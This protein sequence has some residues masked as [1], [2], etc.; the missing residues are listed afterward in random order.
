[1]GCQQSIPTDAG[2]SFDVTKSASALQRT[3]INQIAVTGTFKTKTQSAT[4]SPEAS[5][6]SLR[7]ARTVTSRSIVSLEVD[8]DSSYLLPKLDCNGHLLVEEIVRRTSSSLH[9]SSITVGEGTETFKLQYAYRSQRG[10]NPREPMKPNQEKYGVTLNFAGEGGGAMMGIYSGHGEE[11][12]QCANFSQRVLPQQLAKFVRHKRVQKYR[13]ILQAAGNMKQGAWNPKMWPLL[14]FNDYEQCCERAFRETNKM[15]HQEKDIDDRFSGASVAS[16]CF[17]GGRMYVCNVG[18]SS[19]ILGRRSSDDCTQSSKNYTVFDG[20]EEKCEIEEYT[21]D[22]DPVE[23]AQCPFRGDRIA[24]PLTVK[25]TIY[26]QEEQERVKLAGAEVKQ[27]DQIED[28]ESIYDSKELYDSDS[29]PL[30]AFLPGKS[31][32]S[33]RVT[34]SIG[35]NASEQIGIVSDPDV[36]E[37]DLTVNDDILIIASN[38]ALE[39]LT[40]QE[41]VS[42]CAAN[43][44]PLQASESVTRA[45]YEKWIEHKNRCDDISVII[46]YLSS[47]S[48]QNS[49]SKAMKASTDIYV[50]V[51][52][53]VTEEE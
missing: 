8:E 14:S 33:T 7:T 32:P 6:S 19:V 23:E 26:S 30:R 43:P 10:Y 45:A 15:L 24:I 38:G 13:K 53:D 40:N 41:V 37:C 29:K 16:V 9:C 31:Y 28:A 48:K 51:M 12:Q 22:S 46:C 34:R 35:D 52:V 4:G 20:E 36:I 49:S 11:G 18:E 50:P 5:T 47:L 39:F 17:H 1:M 42:I 3:C 25:H 21:S 44:D 27:S 2:S